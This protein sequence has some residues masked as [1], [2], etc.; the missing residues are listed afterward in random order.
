VNNWDDPEKARE[1]GRKG[2]VALARRRREAREL[3]EL[4]ESLGQEGVAPAGLAAAAGVSPSDERAIL[5]AL[6]DAAKA[7]DVAAS[8]AL[9]ERQRLDAAHGLSAA[10]LGLGRAIDALQPTVQHELREW[11]LEAVR[12]AE[13]P[14]Q[15]ENRQGSDH[16]DQSLPESCAASRRAEGHPP[17]ASESRAALRTEPLNS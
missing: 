3:A 6:T 13:E 10:T 11:L 16:A 15:D 7:G 8:R 14:A 4:A 5:K 17:E 1:A 12:R 9:L 2:G